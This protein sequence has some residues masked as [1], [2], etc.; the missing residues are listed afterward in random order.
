MAVDGSLDDRWVEFEG[1]FNVR[2]LGGL[3]TA[4]GSVVRRGLVFRAD[5]P[6]RLT[7]ADRAKVSG[8]LG[9][10]HVIDLRTG[11]ETEHGS[12][13]A[14]GITGHHFAVIDSIPDLSKEQVEMPK[15]DSPEAMATRYAFRVEGLPDRYAAA[16]ATA[17]EVAPERVLFHCA[18]GKDRTGLI[19]AALLEALGVDRDTIA[20]D[21]GMSAEG[22]RRKIAAEEAAPLEGDTRYDRLPELVKAP[23]AVVMHRFLDL[24]EERHGGFL[25]L[26]RANGLPD[27]RISAFR[28][29]MVG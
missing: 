7:G 3:T 29:L 13:V 20:F 11:P 15:L 9:I 12:W 5:G 17:M 1:A 4:S 22:M 16:A 19:A 24:M 23:S 8:A 18:A 25:A 26:L 21:Y 10:G 6:R 27:E 14:P 2:D 28:T